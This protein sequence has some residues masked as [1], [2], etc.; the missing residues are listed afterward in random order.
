[1]NSHAYDFSMHSMLRRLGAGVLLAVG[2]LGAATAQTPPLY[3]R[4]INYTPANG[5][6]AGEVYSVAIQGAKVWAGTEHGLAL[7]EN[8]QVQKVFTRDD[9]LA[10]YAVMSVAVDHATGAVWVGALGGLSRY[11]GGKFTHYTV[12]SSGLANDLVYN[13]AVRG[14]Y[15]WAA[16]AAGVSRLNIWTHTWRIYS[17]LGQPSAPFKEPWAYALSIGPHKAYMGLWGGGVVTYDLR[18]HTW[19]PYLD[20]DGSAEIV[21]YRNQGLISNMVSS[22]AHGPQS[23][24]FWAGTYFGLSGY[25]GTRWHNYLRQDSGLASN[26]INGVTLEGR[27]VWAATQ[28]GLC[29]FD[30]ATHIWVTYRPANWRALDSGSAARLGRG[31]ILITDPHGR[32]RKLETA[33]SIAHNYILSLAFQGRDIWV[34]TAAGLSHGFASPSR[35][36]HYDDQNRLQPHARPAYARH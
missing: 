27:R 19:R 34:A 30:P 32:Q 15:V 1:M 9:G 17:V 23:N 20:P 13:V 21:L 24:T 25:D 16:T 3:T 10:G 12:L 5:F 29:E 14:H 2:L 26:F 18:Q 4:W 22:L 11:S 35:R 8:G 6:P 36:I 33:S 28:R 31:E 7:I